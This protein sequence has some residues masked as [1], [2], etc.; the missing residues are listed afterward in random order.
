[1]ESELEFTPLTPR[2]ET[3]AIVIHHTG[4]DLDPDAATIH[5][6]HRQR[7]WNGCGYH[8]IIRKDGSI[9]RGRPKWAVGSHAYGRNTDTVGVHIGGEF[10]N[11]EPTQEQMMALTALLADICEKYGLDPA[12]AII[13]HRDT[14]SP[15]ACPGDVLYGMLADVRGAVAE[16][17]AS[18]IKQHKLLVEE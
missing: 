15:T 1:M 13:G 11:S 8:Y 2:L 5:E 14:P 4:A 6:W 16:L 9:E 17:V 10:T 3:T 12:T 7:G 18:N